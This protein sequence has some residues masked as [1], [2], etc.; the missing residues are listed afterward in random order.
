MFA[1]VT[2]VAVL[3]LAGITSASPTPEPLT[4][5]QIAR[6]RGAIEFNE[7]IITNDTYGALRRRAEDWEATHPGLRQDIDAANARTAAIPHYFWTGRIGPNDLSVMDRA[8]QIATKRGGTT[9][10]GTM[11]KV[12]LPTFAGNDPDAEEMWQYASENYAAAARGDVYVIKGE[13]LRRGNVW[14][15]YEY[16]QLKKTPA[17]K[18][19]FMIKAHLLNEEKPVQIFPETKGCDGVFFIDRTISCPAGAKLYHGAVKKPMVTAKTNPAVDAVAKVAAGG[20]APGV[21]RECMEILTGEFISELFTKSGV[22]AAATSKGNNGAVMKNV[23][24]LLTSAKNRKYLQQQR[25][26]K[27]AAKIIDRVIIDALKSH[28]LDSLVA[29]DY[30]QKTQAETAALTKQIDDMVMK[31]T[32]KSPGLTA[33]WKEKSSQLAPTKA[34]LLAELK[35]QIAQKIQQAKE[36]EKR[37]AACGGGAPASPTKP[38][39]HLKR[40]MER[41]YLSTFSPAPMSSLERR[42]AK[43]PRSGAKAPAAPSCPLPNQNKKKVVP[44]DKVKPK[45]APAKKPRVAQT[46]PKAKP[47]ARKTTAKRPASRPRRQP[48]KAAPKKRVTPKKVPRKVPRPA[49]KPKGKARPR[50]R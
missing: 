21:T 17:V 25:I 24:Q 11:A 36:A 39:P 16:P 23:K 8:M 32:G 6:A 41:R 1:R 44:R 50:R 4:A 31:A 20:N 45:P 26:F 43:A 46:K 47:P 33:A 9:L 49:K 13:N 18:R 42:V 40:G 10:E 37:K 3:A 2:A 28:I 12:A 38:K 29:I 7:R 27:L 35:R 15:T 48:G 30:Y 22:C 14:D 5:A 19:I 34:A